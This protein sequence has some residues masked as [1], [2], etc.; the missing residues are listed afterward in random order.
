MK[1]NVYLGAQK[2]WR[3]TTHSNNRQKPSRAQGNECTYSMVNFFRGQQMQ[4][5]GKPK[6]GRKSQ[7]DVGENKLNKQLQELNEMNKD[8]KRIKVE[9]KATFKQINKLKEQKVKG[10]NYYKMQNEID[11]VGKELKSKYPTMFADGNED[12]LRM[13]AQQDVKRRLRIEKK[14]KNG[15]RESSSEGSEDFEIVF[16]K[17]WEDG[18]QKM[19]DRNTY[20]Y[21]TNQ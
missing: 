21:E 13:M 17:S 5:E 18:T 10:I 9:Q 15:E 4:E 6:Q 3:P 16:Q 20:D 1:S 2:M 19:E 14:M 11:M 12:R 7:L 8:L